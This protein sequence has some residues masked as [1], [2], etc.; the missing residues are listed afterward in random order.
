MKPLTRQTAID[1][2]TLHHTK[3]T[4]YFN[5][6]VAIFLP[7]ERWL[8]WMQHTGESTPHEGKGVQGGVVVRKINK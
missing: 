4:R 3:V 2:T 8:K 1:C 5:S 6:G 7:T